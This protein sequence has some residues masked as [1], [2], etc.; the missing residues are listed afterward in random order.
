MNK[1]HNKSATPVV[2]KKSNQKCQVA[3]FMSF[4]PTG[5]VQCLRLSF[6]TCVTTL[7]AGTQLPAGEATVIPVKIQV[8][9]KTVVSRIAPDFI[10]LGYET[11]AVAQ[12][13][14]FNANNTTLVQLYRNLCP[15]GLIRIG[16]NISD[17]TQYVPDGTALV[18]AETGVTI[19]NRASLVDLGEFARA[20]GWKVMW[21]LNL[22]SGSKAGA[23]QEALAVHAA[24]GHALHSFEIGNEVDY[25]RAFKKDFDAYHAAYLE[26]KS[27]IRAALPEAPFSGPDVAGNLN[28]F[29][30]FAKMEGHDVKLLTHHYYRGGAGNPNATVEL[31]LKPDARW[32]GILEILQQTSQA[33]G[34]GYQIN[35]VNSFSG[36][37]KT[38]VSDTFASALWC[39]DYMF[40]LAGHGC[41]GINLETDINQH[42][43]ISHYSPIVH[44]A[45]GRCN[46]R[47]EYYGMLAF[48]MAGNG[49]LLK[50]T[51]DEGE[52]NLSAYA[53][54]DKRGY[55][56]ITV[57]N[58]ELSQAAGVELVLPAGYETAAL[59]WLKAPSVLSKDQISFA[60]AEVSADGRW[61]AGLP[62]RVA[63]NQGAVHMQV[64]HASAVLVRLK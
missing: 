6:L 60:G 50:L 53:T 19:I 29:T 2:G 11:S 5:K 20:T 58:K 36:G 12:T 48:A 28:W 7:L 9:P 43:W 31:L 30:N 63:V 59:A 32:A 41:N 40:V 10:G 46:A 26:Y 27:A 62:E 25:H 64:P 39:L 21:G 42:A 38:N 52:V 54:R 61:T 51:L 57:V 18:Q 35:E 22:G 15:H 8:D 24:L 17:R 23:V 37:G 13:N 49:D 14:Y 34:I 56:W 45:T 1:N 55:L 44:D 47:P 33:Q 3:F 4:M 16:G